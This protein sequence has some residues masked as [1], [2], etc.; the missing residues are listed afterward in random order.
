[1]TLKVG[2]VMV[3]VLPAVVPQPVAEVPPW[4]AAPPPPGW[5]AWQVLLVPPA[6]RPGH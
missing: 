5:Q 2:Y 6:L 1:M 4:A 3:Q